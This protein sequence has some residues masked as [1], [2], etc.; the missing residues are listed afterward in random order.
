MPGWNSD[1][2]GLT[3]Y[4]SLPEAARNYLQYVAEDLGVEILLVSTGAK[5]VETIM[6]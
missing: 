1:T 3:T 2:T 4:K 5:R 6:C